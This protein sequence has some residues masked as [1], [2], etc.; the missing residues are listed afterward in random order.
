MLDK[1]LF[2]QDDYSELFSKILFDF[3]QNGPVDSN[4]L[5]TLSLL[6]LNHSDFFSKYESRLLYL[7][8]LFYKTD[9]P[10]SFLELIYDIYSKSIE[11]STGRTF[12]PVQA[13]AYNSIFKYDKFSF[14]APTSTGKSFLFQEII[15]DINGDVIVVVPSRALLS[16]YVIKIKKVT[17]KDI[18]VLP[19]IEFVNTKRTHKRIFVIT[20][21]RGDELFKNINKI[22]IELFLFDEAQLTEEGIRG[23]KFDSFVRRVE[24]KIPDAKKVFTHPFVKNPEAQ[25]IKHDL[26]IDSSS[27]SYRQNNV[28]KIFLEHKKS[29]FKYFSPYQDNSNGEIKYDGDIVEHI[30][31]NGGTCLIYVSKGKIYD[32]SFI[33]TYSKY[34][35]LCPDITDKRALEYISELEDYFGTSRDKQ[36]LVIYLMK[37]GIVIHHGSM[38]LKARLIIE[39]F[40]NESYAKLCFSTS[41]LI[42]G[43][44]MPFDLVWINNFHF[45]GNE[46]KKNLDLK[47]LIGRAGRTTS[48]KN[49][50]DYGFVVV[51]SLNKGSFISRINSESSISETSLLDETNDSFD[52][53]FI[54]IIDAIRNDTFDVELNLTNTQIERLKSDDIEKEVKY[55]LDNLM[56]NKKPL[57]GHEYYSISDSVRKNIKSSFQNIY[58]THLRR[59][60]LTSGEKSVLSASIPVLLWQIQGKSFAEI[61]SL[62]H[63]FLS[64]KDIRRQLRRQ[65]RSG[66][67]TVKEYHIQLESTKIRFS[68]IA[69]SLPNRKFTKP[70]ALFKR[71]LSVKDID[72]DLIIY[73]TYDYI[74]KV[75]SLSLKDPLSAAFLLYYNKHKDLRALYLSNYIT[76]G[77]NNQTEIWLLKYG[78]TFDEIEWILPFV[79]NINEQEIIFKESIVDILNDEY[80]KE[81]IE[82]Y[83]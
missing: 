44:N 22:N 60:D 16:E 36:S 74:D 47:N 64:E 1:D 9:S 39:K 48:T 42:Q 23:M 37:K 28:G 81:I 4:H 80:K 38:P 21:E 76:Y 31:S 68:C 18:L 12:T 57:T 51:E 55:I 11:E 49:V 29:I 33:E 13:D 53:D 26:L 83:I 66:D 43:I 2:E 24:K 17:P 30:L 82:R 20:P 25:L 46:N 8:G 54:D 69:E 32:S 35:Q 34:L 52:E 63:A 6:K 73:D 50:F 61:V 14:S 71:N 19:F 5:E 58:K 77:T 70:V 75:I 59:N 15:K 62:R 67:I 27:E 45:T 3:H 40:V 72:F 10:S 56:N 79:E 65:L 41:T 78:F 7:M